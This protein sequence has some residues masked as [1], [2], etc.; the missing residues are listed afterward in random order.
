MYPNPSNA[1]T[2]LSFDLVEDSPVVVSLYNATGQLVEV[3]LNEVRPAGRNEVTVNI[4]FLTSGVY[5]YRL[6]TP[7][8]THSGTMTRIK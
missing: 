1:T 7:D 5:I 2:T 8:A 3:L 4:P 6:E